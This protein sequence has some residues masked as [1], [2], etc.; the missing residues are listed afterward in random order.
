MAHVEVVDG[1][2][3]LRDDWCVEDVLQECTWLTE[4]EEEEEEEEEAEVVLE[5]VADNFDANN[6]INWQVIHCTAEELY[7]EPKE[8]DKGD[9]DGS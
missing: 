4:E 3:I 9:N 5:A 7:P 2:S 8:I 1:K 6:G